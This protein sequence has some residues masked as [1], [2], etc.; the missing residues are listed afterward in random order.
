MKKRLILW[1]VLFAALA[2]CARGES[3]METYT[4][5]D[6][7]SMNVWY[8]CEEFDGR[9]PREISSVFEA[10]LRDGDE[11]ICG[12]D[13]EARLYSEPDIQW[14]A[15]AL[16]AVRREG[17]ILLMSARR[18]EGKWLAVL[19]TDSFLGPQTQFDIAIE[20]KQGESGSFLGAHLAIVTQKGS[21]RIDVLNGGAAALRA[22]Q[23]AQ[24]D[25][26]ALN[27]EYYNGFIVNTVQAGQDS[28]MFDACAVPRRLAAWT[29]ESVP[30][31]VEEIK[32]WAAA[33][34]IELQADEAYISGVNLR[35]KPTGKS[36][37]MGIYSAKVSVL[38]SRSGLQDPWYHVRVGDTEGWVSGNYL[39]RKEDDDPRFESAAASFFSV[40]RADREIALH[41]APNGKKKQSIPALTSMHVITEN[42]GWLH[43]V[44]P[45]SEIT[46]AIDWDGTYGFVKASDVTQGETLTELK[47]K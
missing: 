34:P 21:Y 9:L 17:K 18:K 37:S 26:T 16:I 5:G 41:I 44:I 31:S 2:V 38:D 20:Q 35:E 19:E 14:D 45:R 23:G 3:F 43:V 7:D 36:R 28:H 8:A 12:A 33:H 4:L 29:E 11:I 42:E 40:A 13:F 25:G 46:W 24:A 6:R 10:L 1:A 30:G 27:I 15:Q 47:W 39:V 32:A 22:F